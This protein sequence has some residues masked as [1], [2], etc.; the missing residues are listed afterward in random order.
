MNRLAEFIRKSPMTV[1]QVAEAANLTR[2]SVNRIKAGKVKL[3]ENT[4]F[5]FAKALNCYPSELLPLEWQKPN[6]HD[7]DVKILADSIREVTEAAN[8]TKKAESM[9]PSE[10]LYELMALLYNDKIIKNN[11]ISK[12]PKVLHEQSS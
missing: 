2:D 5:R 12:T 4:L 7:I 3:N 8:N 6:S 1:E 9:L 11:K 10:K